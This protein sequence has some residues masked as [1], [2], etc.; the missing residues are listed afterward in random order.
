MT[1]SIDMTDIQPHLNTIQGLVGDIIELECNRADLNQSCSEKITGK[2]PVTFKKQNGNKQSI[3]HEYYY[4][5]SPLSRVQH[6][7]R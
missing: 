7:R 2:I 4:I 1:P 3:I 6:S 5:R